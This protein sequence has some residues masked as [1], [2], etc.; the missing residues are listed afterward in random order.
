MARL[1]N[2]KQIVAGS[3]SEAKLASGA[4]TWKKPV[5]VKH[6]VG[7]ATITT[8]NGLTPT[9]GDAYVATA[10]GTPTAGTS[11]ALVI[12]SIAEYDGTSWI[13]IVTGSGGFVPDGTRA[14]L[15]TQTALIAPYTDTS[16]D[17][18]IRS[19]D[20]TSLTG[21]DTGEA[22]DGYTVV[23]SG[24]SGVFENSLLVFSGSV[25]TGSWAGG[26][27]T[28]AGS[29]LTESPLD[30]F[31]V[32]DAGKGVQELRACVH[33]T[34]VERIVPA[35]ELLDL[36]TLPG[37]QQS[38]VNEHG[39][40]LLAHGPAQQGGHHGRIHAARQATNDAIIA[41]AGTHFRH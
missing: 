31:N 23:V 26:G 28:S 18:Q 13:E 29:G 6:L 34:E 7:N 25:P 12:G 9:Q 35:E 37:P 24:D 1:L 19:F 21:V 20:G 8:I 17:G 10:A 4:V 2:G 11:D 30:T 15:A 40:H 27:N 39:E 14:L 5:A 41:D 36:L 32:G 38:V 22:V 33:H 16:H 3:I